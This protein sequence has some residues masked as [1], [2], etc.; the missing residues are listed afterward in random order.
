LSLAFLFDLDGVIVDSMPLHVAVWREY[1]DLHSIDGADLLA[2]MHGARND[3]LVR[4]LF[5]PQLS[6]EEV[7][8]HGAAKEALFR[9]RLTARDHLVPGVTDFL[10]RYTSVPKAVG[11][12]AEM[13]NIDHVLQGANLQ[14]H[15]TAVVDGSQVD[16]AK[17]APDIYWKAAE[18]LGRAPAECIVFEDSPTGIAAGVAA[19]MRVVGVNTARLA[20]FPKVDL[21]IDDFTS[22]DLEPWLLK[23]QLGT[24]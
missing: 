20:D 13:A 21:V 7:F 22:P 18:R 12:N 1:L 2:H 17:P 11:S 6:D 19:G 23:Q 4:V 3:A 15:F 16:R 10:H 8:A 24:R 5:G 9:E 14:R